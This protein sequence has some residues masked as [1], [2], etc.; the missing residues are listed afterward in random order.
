[1]SVHEDLERRPAKLEIDK[2]SIPMSG[3][4]FLLVQRDLKSL[5]SCPRFRVLDHLH[6]NGDAARPAHIPA[7]VNVVTVARLGILP[8]WL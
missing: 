1:M 5:S 8:G 2:T 3:Q 7:T 4:H 6:A